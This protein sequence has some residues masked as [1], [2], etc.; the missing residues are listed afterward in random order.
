MQ[1]NARL[2]CPRWRFIDARHFNPA[3]V[4]RPLLNRVARILRLGGR[5]D[6]QRKIRHHAVTP[7]DFLPRL[8]APEHAGQH[9]AAWHGDVLRA[10]PR[11]KAVV[12][13]AFHGKS[14]LPPAV[15]AFTFIGAD[16]ERAAS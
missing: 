16:D 1:F 4:D 15:Q 14:F 12:L 10:V 11:G 8:I 6:A 13:L 7:F 3:V 9:A 5:H 2:R